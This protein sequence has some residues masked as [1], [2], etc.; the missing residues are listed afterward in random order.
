M[1]TFGDRTGP[2]RGY[3]QRVLGYCHDSVG[4]GHLRRTLTICERLGRAFPQASFLLATG[5]PYFPMFN[6]S[7]PIDYIKLP[8]LAKRED[9]AYCCKYLGVPLERLLRCRESLL[10]KTTESFE[11]DVLLVDKAPLGVCQEL[12]PTLRWLRRQ[13]PRVRTIFGMRDIEDAPRATIAQW[14][15]IGAFELIEEFYD[16]VWVY[17]MRRVFDVGVKYRLSP[18]IRAKLRYMGYLHRAPCDHPLPSDRDGR[19]ILVTVGGGTDGEHVIGTY[20]AEAA[21]RAA[22]MGIRST[23]IGGPDLPQQAAASLGDIAS[24]IEGVEWVAFEGCMSCRMRRSELVVSMGGYNTLCEIAAHRKP[25]LVIPRTH[26]RLEQT[27]RAKLWER[28]HAVRV[29][30]RAAL[31]PHT[32]AH[33]VLEMLA[34][35]PKTTNPQLDFKG[36]D[37]I[38]ERFPALWREE[39][40]RAAAVR[41]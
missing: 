12:V 39:A 18:R 35:G 10:L 28:R 32:L 38:V 1:R 3:P 29:L 4:V 13:R 15:R 19:E 37:R 27:L 21:R 20:L 8:A 34:N 9:G 23:I 5:T 41:L 36:L 30:D 40:R 25:A 22:T 14:A 33:R 31:T 11:P 7:A 17:G 26:P 24:T 6:P 16:E 2:Q